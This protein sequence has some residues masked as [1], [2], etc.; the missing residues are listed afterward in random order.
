MDTIPRGVCLLINNVKFEINLATRTG[1]EI[2]AFK[3]TKLFQDFLLFQVQLEN[4]VTISKLRR[5]LSDLQHEDHSEYSAFAMV[6]LSHGDN[7]GV[8]YCSDG[9]A[10]TI[11]EISSH[12]SAT[13]CPSLYGKPK[14]FFIQACRGQKSNQV[15]Q[16][17]HPQPRI[18]TY[19]SHFISPAPNLAD[20]LFSFATIEDFAAMRDLQDG[21]W[22]INEL[23]CMIREGARKED[24]SRIL[25]KVANSVSKYQ[26]GSLMQVPE[27]V[28]QLRKKLYF[29]PR[30]ECNFYLVL[31]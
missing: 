24:L 11:K 23:I 16:L 6:F 29:F 12:F 21:S 27:H 2:D 28:L 4:D 8:V 5:I 15:V 19:I 1:S 17:L 22:Y 30:Q 18:D 10:I 31:I 13:R 3:L 26:H 14:L 9:N 7:G 20:F 25:T